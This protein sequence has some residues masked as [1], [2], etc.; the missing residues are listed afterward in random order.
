MWKSGFDG[1]KFVEVFGCTRNSSVFPTGEDME[2][3]EVGLS[4]DRNLDGYLGTC[5]YSLLVKVPKL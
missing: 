4:D 2:E 5:W 1:V 3:G